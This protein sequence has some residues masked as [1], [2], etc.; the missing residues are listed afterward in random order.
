MRHNVACEH[1]CDTQ[2]CQVVLGIGQ[3]KAKAGRGRLEAQ[4]ETNA[5]GLMQG[6]AGLGP[7]NPTS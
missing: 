4:Q 7:R 1:D 3:T 5:Q 2:Q 6:Q